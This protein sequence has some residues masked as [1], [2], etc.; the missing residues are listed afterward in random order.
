MPLESKPKRNL[1]SRFQQVDVQ[2]D[3]P[4]FFEY[5]DH[6]GKLPGIE[7]SRC[8]G[9]QF[10]VGI[11]KGRIVDIGCGVGTM[12]ARIASTVP[13]PVEVLGLDKSSMMIAQASARHSKIQR[14][15]FS[16][17]SFDSIEASSVEALW[18]ERVL[19]H[20]PEPNLA[21]S[22]CVRALRPDGRVVV[23]EPDWGSLVINS[24]DESLQSKWKVDLCEFQ[25]NGAIGR[26]L[27][28]LFRDNSLR[29]E[30]YEGF[31]IR[32]E[33]LVELNNIV[34]IDW[35]LNAAVSREALTA[36]E[37][38]ALLKQLKGG[39]A[40]GKVCGLF[41]IAAAFGTLAR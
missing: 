20:T 27:P 28:V 4:L 11:D 24:V 26:S 37:A 8:S 34:N 38:E 2:R 16:T 41:V 19:V 31:V 3:P 7:R 21:F 35:S 39:D 6:L 12:A 33:S 22:Q 15:G 1:G 10:L 14:L 25:V 36:T 40:M 30:V 9:L 17:G 23:L 18:V 13:D 32:F 5:L 29:M